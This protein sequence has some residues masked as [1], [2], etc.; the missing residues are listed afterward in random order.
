MSTNLV[1]VGESPQ[2]HEPRASESLQVF[3]TCPSSLATPDDYVKRIT[4]VALWSEAAGCTGILIYTD[5]SLVDPW[6]VSQIILQRTNALCPLVA[7][8]PVYLHP[9][10]VA[11]MVS[12]LAF[13]HSRRVFLNMVAGG[14]KNDL[15][16]LGDATPHDSRY[17]RL[18]EYTHI[19][20]RLLDGSSPVTFQGQFYQVKNLT[21]NPRMAT[22]LRPGFL[23][24]G[25][26]E[27]GMAAAQS[28]GAVAV[29]YPEPPGKS[30]AAQSADSGPRGIRIGIVT[31][32]REEDA[33]E[34]AYTRFPED[35]QGQ[36]TRQFATKVSDSAWHHRLSEIGQQSDGPRDTYW[37]HPFENY[38]TNCPYL[39]GAYDDV[40]GQVSRYMQLGFR[41][42]ILDIPAAE[43]EFEHIGRVFEAARSAVR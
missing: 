5:N 28:T 34:V 24:S 16:A 26:S 40:A 11:K 23:M 33:W 10:S 22:E 35:R 41:T 39:V 36:L 14:F 32:P 4:D 20:Q 27:A 1:L 7:V 29:Q 17:Q 42:F 6:L 9:Y 37:L 3:S 43:E 15:T 30:D 31:R 25:S 38:Q 8:Q 2:V 12:T 19:I 13:L 21:L 18:V